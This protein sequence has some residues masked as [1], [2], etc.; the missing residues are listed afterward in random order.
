[1]NDNETQPPI[2][3]EVDVKEENGNLVVTVDNYYVATIPIQNVNVE[4][5]DMIVDLL[6]KKIFAGL[7]HSVILAIYTHYRKQAN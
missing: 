6:Q 7:H 4:T 2:K 5:I 1:M 3:G